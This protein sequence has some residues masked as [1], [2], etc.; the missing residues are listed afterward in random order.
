[1]DTE[2]SARS[3]SNSSQGR[4]QVLVA[5]RRH[6]RLGKERKDRFIQLGKKAFIM[7]IHSGGRPEGG[8][9]APIDLNPGGRNRTRVARPWSRLPAIGVQKVWRKYRPKL[10]PELCR[11]SSGTRAP[12]GMVPS[13]G[14]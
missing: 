9:A 3:S 13:N 8:L 12:A 7:N 6:A 1:M 5:G 10:L 2:G 11:L 14:K 4:W